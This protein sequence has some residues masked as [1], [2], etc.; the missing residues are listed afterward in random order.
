[1][2]KPLIW[3]GGALAVAG[4]L[5][6]AFFVL[7]YIGSPPSEA[8]AEHVTLAATP[9]VAVLA[10]ATALAAGA[11]LIGVGVGRWQRPR[12]TETLPYGQTRHSSEV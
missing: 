4:V 9:L 1:M 3:I 12:H 6:I 2:G 7:P 10:G 8:T 11:A 5:A